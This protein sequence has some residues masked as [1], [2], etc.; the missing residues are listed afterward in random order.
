M[1]AT[2]VLAWGILATCVAGCTP[3]VPRTYLTWAVTGEPLPPATVPVAEDTLPSGVAP[4]AGTVSHH[5]LADSLIDRWF[6]A[7]ARARSVKVFYILSPSHWDLSVQPVS[8]TT[9]RWS[10]PGGWVESARPQVERLA[11]RLQVPLEP[12]VFDAEHG[13]STL[14]PY[15]AKYFP[16]A[17]VVAVAYRGE[18]PVDQPL[19][20][21]IA[22]ALEPE[23][24]AWGRR[25]HFLL[26]STD[27]AHHG[28]FAGTVT[29]DN[30]SRL[31]FEK[32]GPDRWI[33]VGCDNRPGIYTLAR[34]AAPDEMSTILFHSNSWQL[35]GAQPDD[36]TSYFFSFFWTPG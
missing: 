35:S 15:V 32:P 27:F 7:L 11:K 26:V 3:E 23:F 30:R 25:D 36:I 18:P 29:K 31:F 13:V 14:M 22:D 2:A 28:D 4:W 20:A 16:Q 6:A 17:Q 21:R 12:R 5:L 24:D 1:R 10:V 9:G 34:L 8:L 33:L 19:A